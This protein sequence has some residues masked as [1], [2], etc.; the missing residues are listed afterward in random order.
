MIGS[1][2][3]MEITV[4]AIL[5]LLL[6]GPKGLPKLGKSLGKAIRDFKR[7]ANELKSAV[8]LEVE[9]EEWREEQEKKKKQKPQKNE[10]ATKKKKEE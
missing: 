8:E 7:E 6:V 2:G 1:L 4:I 9:E 3:W 10:P 5:A